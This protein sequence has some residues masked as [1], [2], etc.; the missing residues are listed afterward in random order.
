MSEWTGIRRPSEL[1]A[2]W[3][4]CEIN[5]QFLILMTEAAED[6]EPRL[7]LARELRPWLLPQ[8]PMLLSLIAASPFLLV[9]AG[10][11]DSYR[12][13]HVAELIAGARPERP[14]NAWLPRSEGT[15]LARTTLLFTWQIACFEPRLAALFSG[16]S[17]EVAQAIAHLT[18]SQLLFIAEYHYDWIR[19]R[20]EYRPETWRLLIDTARLDEAQSS[21]TLL[22]QELFIGDQLAHPE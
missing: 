22:A 6:S 10:F 18:S 16:A 21:V 8:D 2:L 11:T 3:N 20:W 1:H 19:P 12:W 17:L 5:A 15:A 13:R 14:R 4:V 9:D 7:D